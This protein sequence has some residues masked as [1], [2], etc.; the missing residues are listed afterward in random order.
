MMTLSASIGIYLFM[1]VVMIDDHQRALNIKKGAVGTCK[2]H[3][4]VL[5][6]PMRAVLLRAFCKATILM[7]YSVPG[8][9]PTAR[10]NKRRTRELMCTR[11]SS[12]TQ[13][14]RAKP[15]V[16]NGIALN[17]VWS[18]DKLLRQTP[19]FFIGDI[20]PCNTWAA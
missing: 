2:V 12:C 16:D 18:G 7:T 4:R 5:A 13:A 11:Y 19:C 15:T 14:T 3:L 17:C 20:V 9:R 8:F 6:F 10:D 1:L